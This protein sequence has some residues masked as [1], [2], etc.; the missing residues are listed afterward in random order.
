MNRRSLL[1][2][3]AASPL[4]FL[5]PKTRSG[6]EY[7][8]PAIVGEE[9][10]PGWTYDGEGFVKTRPECTFSL[11]EYSSPWYKKATCGGATLNPKW[12]Q[13]CTMWKDGTVVKQWDEDVTITI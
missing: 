9:K 12:K 8:G 7:L 6:I 4:G 13:T 10:P 2:M 3:L 11:I 1:K 5:V